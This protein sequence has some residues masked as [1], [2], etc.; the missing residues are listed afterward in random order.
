M[1]KPKPKWYRSNRWICEE[2]KNWSDRNLP[3]KDKIC[4]TCHR[5]EI[6]KSKKKTAEI[7]PHSGV[8]TGRT[9][10]QSDGLIFIWK[11]SHKFYFIEKR[12]VNRNIKF[13]VPV[14]CE[15]Q[16]N[17]IYVIYAKYTDGDVGRIESKRK[18][19][20]KNRERGHS[21]AEEKFCFLC[22]DGGV[23]F[24]VF[25]TFIRRLRV[26][27]KN[28][29]ISAFRSIHLFRTSVDTNNKLNGAKRFEWE[30]LIK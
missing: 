27:E 1:Y 24:A 15:S 14:F 2:K 8:R 9:E 28:V 20:D 26:S 6:A 29:Y 25:T 22:A 12:L 16:L 13:D 5:I 19:P 3:S 21:K 10:S 17:R 18:Q 23:F 11:N 7:C 4:F 30:V